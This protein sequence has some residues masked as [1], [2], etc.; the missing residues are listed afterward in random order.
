MRNFFV[1]SCLILLS[2]LSCNKKDSNTSSQ[3]MVNR[4]SVKEIMNSKQK[5][6]RRCYERGLEANEKLAGRVEIKLEY[7]KSGT[8]NNCI[9][10]KQLGDQGVGKCICEATQS[11]KFSSSFEPSNVVT[12]NWDLKPGAPA[13]E[14]VGIAAADL[15]VIKKK[16]I[17]VVMCYEEELK[18]NKQIE[19]DL[20]VVIHLND[21]GSVKKCELKKNVSEPAVG[22]CV[23]G[24]IQKW[25][26]GKPEK[27]GKVI[28]YNWYLK[29]KE[30]DQKTE[31]ENKNGSGAMDG[32]K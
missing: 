23:C 11:W 22:Q 5:D 14:E 27:P 20:S 24:A 9:A 6:V 15:E 8:V 21:D 16:Q 31:S 4:G 26:F 7:D 1:H 13:K 28:F 25:R 32:E 30:A 18:K 10:T 2:T 3:K 19:G 17:D 12:W 29:P